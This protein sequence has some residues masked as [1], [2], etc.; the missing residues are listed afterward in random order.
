M[1]SKKN[2]ASVET[3]A[4]GK[5]E[6]VKPEGSEQSGLGPQLISDDDMQGKT[7][8]A[9]PPVFYA[10]H[11]DVD[12]RID[13]LRRELL[14]AIAASAP[15]HITDDA[16]PPAVGVPRNGIT[17]SV[18]VP[19]FCPE[20]GLKIEGG[21]LTGINGTP[22]EHPFGTSPKISG[23]RCKYQGKKFRPP[24]MFLELV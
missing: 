6:R 24:V 9:P 2:T 20:C 15:L 8:S 17:A 5:T 10:T 7:A 22:Y 1:V 18:L 13:T 21:S 4:D 19:V 16:I 14:Q 23:Q 11:G 12:S 3:D